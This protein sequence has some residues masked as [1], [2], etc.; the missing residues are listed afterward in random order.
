MLWL[1]SPLSA[2][3]LNGVA[4]LSLDDVGAKLGMKSRWVEKG[5][6]LELRSEWT[7]LRFELHK[8]EMTVNGLRVHLGYPVARQRGELYL[9]ETDYRHQIQPIL[10]PQVFGA[11]PVIRHVIIDAG[12]G[13]SDPGAEN[14]SLKLREK[15][16]TLDLAKR[17]KAQLEKAG[18][19]VSMIR[20]GDRLVA[21]PERSRLANDL[22]GDLFLS[23]HFNAST[24]TK[25]HGVETYAFTPLLQPST[26][27]TKLH[28]S[29]RQ[30]YAGNANDPWSELLGFYVQRSLSEQLPSPDRGL[31]RARFTVL[32]DLKMPGIL[33][34][35]GFVTHP[36]EG[37]NIGSAGYRDKIAE[38]IVQGLK[39]FEGTAARLRSRTQ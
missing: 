16:L 12:H 17:V 35:G 1:V 32:R 31:K 21:L 27:R 2:L 3:E 30:S 26:S 20:S 7:R 11:P 9:S 39:T 4:H 15:N 10:T 38:A 13:G 18:Y 8:R 28:E 34:E 23:L 5:E 33:I 37:R 14:A 19:T 6:I 22:N 24:D 36:K 29:D 25:V